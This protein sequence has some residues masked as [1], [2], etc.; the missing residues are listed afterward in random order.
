MIHF[1]TMDDEKYT[2]EQVLGK[3]KINPA[4]LIEFWNTNIRKE[5][6]YS[7]KQMKD[8]RTF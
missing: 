5:V 7:L 3:A 1:R 6:G 2:E 4:K 8:P